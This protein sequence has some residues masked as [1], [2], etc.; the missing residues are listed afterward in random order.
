MISASWSQVAA[1]AVLGQALILLV[2]AIAFGEISL[3]NLARPGA[4]ILRVN[5]WHLLAHLAMGAS[6]VIAILDRRMARPWAVAAGLT[7]LAWAVGGV[8]S[9]G[10][11][12][13]L[14][15]EDTTGSILH[16]LEGVALMAVGIRS[17]IGPAQLRR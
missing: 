8:T 12:L 10:A 6:G 3:T 15:D 13:G 4:V 17:G 14:I 5:G 1:L 11:L 2:L 16:A 7:S 9:H